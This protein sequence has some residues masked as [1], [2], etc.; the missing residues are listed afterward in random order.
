MHIHQNAYASMYQENN[1]DF[2]HRCFLLKY[3]SIDVQYRCVYIYIKNKL[4]RS[5]DL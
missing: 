3:T 5:L 2:S 4:Q 1:F